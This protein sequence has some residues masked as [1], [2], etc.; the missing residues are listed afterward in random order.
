MAATAKQ[1]TGRHGVIS[2][3]GVE[4]VRVWAALDATD[5]A[6]ATSTIVAAAPATVGSMVLDTLTYAERVLDHY[7]CELTYR[8]YKRRNPPAV[9]ESQ[10][11]FDVSIVPVKVIVPLS[12]PTV[13]KRS[14][15]AFPLPADSARWLIGD[16]GDGNGPEGADI[17]EPAIA[18]SKTCWVAES[19]L[20]VSYRNQISR[21]VAKVNDSPFFG[22]DEGEVLCGG[23][24]GAKRGDSDVEL[25]FRFQAKENQYG[26]EV[27]GITG[28][29]KEGWQYLDPKYHLKADGDSYIVTN[30]IRYISINH[31][32][33]KGDFSLLGIGT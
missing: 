23:I 29:D 13:Y 30:V 1:I 5:E 18:F 31:V 8:T 16:Q 4:T 22:W 6:D 3:D 7:E 21:I 15:D 12:A 14:D 10:F 9:N 2:G 26:I 27:A 11:N 17:Y 33:R 25:T 19:L 24:S 28:I 20:D 32:F